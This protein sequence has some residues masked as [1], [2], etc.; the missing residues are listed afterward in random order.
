MLRWAVKVVAFAVLTLIGILTF[1]PKVFLPYGGVLAALV[2][3][4]VERIERR[5]R[6]I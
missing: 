2:V 1:G 6:R 4:G 5:V 3:E